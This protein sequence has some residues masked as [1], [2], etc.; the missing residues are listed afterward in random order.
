LKQASWADLLRPWIG[1]VLSSSE[2]VNDIQRAAGELVMALP[3]GSGLLLVHHGLVKDEATGEAC[4]LI[5][6]DLYN[7]NQMETT[8]A[9]GCLNFLNTQSRLFFRWCITDQLHKAMGPVSISS[10]RDH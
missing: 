7:E 1:G 2:V 4:Y 8:N 9:L 6:A 10:D 5:D 3:E